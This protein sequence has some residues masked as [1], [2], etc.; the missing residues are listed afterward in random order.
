[1]N[2]Q[3]EEIMENEGIIAVCEYPLELE[4]E[5]SGSFASGLFAEMVV[6]YFEEKYLP[7]NEVKD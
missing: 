1:M 6:S 4:H 3:I 5:E 7:E 2:K